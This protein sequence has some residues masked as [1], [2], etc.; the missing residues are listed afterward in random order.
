MISFIVIGKNEGWKLTK[1]FE[2]I[3]NTVAYNQV[4]NYELIYVDQPQLTTVLKGK[5][6]C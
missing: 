2:S 1:C 3:F 4:M 5:S 6:I